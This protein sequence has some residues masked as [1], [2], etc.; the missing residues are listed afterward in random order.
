LSALRNNKY[1]MADC[2]RSGTL[3]AV[4]SGYRITYNASSAAAAA[5]RYRYP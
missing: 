1:L 2:N 3:P 5:A 4:I